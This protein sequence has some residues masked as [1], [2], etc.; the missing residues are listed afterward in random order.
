MGILTPDEISR[1]SPPERLALIG[2][3]WDSLGGV[4][5]PLTPAQQTELGRRLERFD[6]D[7]AEGMDWSEFKVELGKRVP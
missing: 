6:Q 3:L 5:L 1:L 7:L 4:E 2:D